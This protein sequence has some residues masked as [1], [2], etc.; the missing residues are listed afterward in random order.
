LRI[1]IFG[2][3]GMS[4]IAVQENHLAKHGGEIAAA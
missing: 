1:N 2:W 3:N 4:G